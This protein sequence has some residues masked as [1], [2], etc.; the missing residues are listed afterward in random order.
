MRDFFGPAGPLPEEASLVE[1][2]RLPRILSARLLMRLL[3]RRCSYGVPA[4]LWA[5]S[6]LG[7]RLAPPT[8]EEVLAT[9]FLSPEQTFRTFQTALRADLEDLEYRCLSSSF[10]ERKGIMQLGW[11]EFREKLLRD[12]PWL[13]HAARARILETVALAED[14][15]RIVAE[16]NT[17]F[18]DAQFAVLL[19][20]EDS[21]Q[22]ADASG[23]LEGAYASWREIVRADGQTLELRI[24]RPQGVELDELAEI[25]AVRQWKI[26][27]FDILEEP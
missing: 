3:K 9:G 14:R 5:A 12:E 13:R 19:V 7:C 21:Y 17:L 8:P 6:S 2:V 23:P 26:E 11:R 15:S 24:P 4:L 25:Q 22:T 20:R 10:K 27:S 18:A 1:P 16:V